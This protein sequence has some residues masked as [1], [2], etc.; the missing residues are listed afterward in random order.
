VHL[1]LS[2]ITAPSCPENSLMYDFVES[3]LHPDKITHTRRQEE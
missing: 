3:F 1:L 2:L